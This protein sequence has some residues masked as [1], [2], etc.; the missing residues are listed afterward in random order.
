MFTNLFIYNSHENWRVF[1]RR[2]KAYDLLQAHVHDLNQ[3]VYAKSK[4]Q[5]NEGDC[6]KVKKEFYTKKKKVKKQ[7]CPF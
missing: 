6:I 3:E 7:N 1:T 5:K 2:K 4:H